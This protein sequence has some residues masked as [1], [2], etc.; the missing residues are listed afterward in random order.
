[1]ATL[2]IDPHAERRLRRQR[3]RNGTDRWDEVWNGVYVMSPLP[4]D[5]HQDIGL[6]IATALRRAVQQNGLGVV[7]HGTNVSDRRTDWVKNYRCPD[8]AVF[9]TGNPAENLSTHWFGGPDLAIEIVSP[10]DRSRRKLPFYARVATQ[11]VLILDRNPWRLELYRLTNGELVSVG[12][13]TLAGGE[14]LRTRSVPFS[15]RLID[16]SERPVVEM[17]HVEDGNRHQV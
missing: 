16:G 9:L 12:T 6:G 3:Q 13:A 2:I 1:M 4:N 11:E 17:V 10:R 14:T 7:R 15:W 8:V 5:Q